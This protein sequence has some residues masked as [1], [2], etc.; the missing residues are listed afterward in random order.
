[1]VN[2]LRN[3]DLVLKRYE[4]NSMKGF[5]KKVLL[6]ASVAMAVGSIS[7][8]ANACS[9]LVWE[10]QDHGVFVSRTM[11]WMEANQ[12]T[13]DVRHAG[14]T[15]RGYDKDDALTWTSK[16][17]SIGVS[18]YGVGII[19]GFNEKGFAAN[20][21]FLDEEN[22]GAPQAG[23]Q[24]IENSR[25]VAYLIDS[26]ASVDE[27]LK[28][29]D[30][31]QIQQFSHNGIE[32]KGHYSLEDASG[33]SAVLEYIDGAWQVH[34]GKQY[35]VM[36]NSPEY[37]QH[38]KNWQ[39]AQPKAKSDVNGEYP[40]PGNINSAQRFVWNSY[41]KDQ[42]KEPS[43]YTNGIAKLDS[44]TYKIPLDAANRPVNGEMRG[45]ATIYGLVYNLD[46][47]VMN[48]RYQYDDSYTQYSV[49]FNKLNDGHN[50]TIKA[51][52]PDLFGDISSRLVK[53]DGVMGQ[54]LAK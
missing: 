44:V 21:L 2:I 22:P 3:N 43:S 1:M 5:S 25:F 19:D 13:I 37:A 24:Q 17:A 31:I 8:A 48:V 35:D 41:M 39:E 20:A 38:L 15:Y 9:R 27:A 10:T 7:T 36:T 4:G 29:L 42:L 26:F 11:D 34:H 30:S 54:H 14:Q 6:A 18:I 40:I 16:Y 45:Y 28:H 52:L 53:G 51:D 12:P 50:Y 46:Q 49:D 47:K 23:K 33:D 32:M